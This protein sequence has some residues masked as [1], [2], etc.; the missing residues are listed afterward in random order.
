VALH[1]ALVEIFPMSFHRSILLI[2]I[3]ASEKP[4][5]IHRYPCSRTWESLSS[6]SACRP[7]RET[8]TALS[9]DEGSTGIFSKMKGRVD[10]DYQV[11]G[12]SIPTHHDGDLDD[13]WRVDRRH[14]VRLDQTFGHLKACWRDRYLWAAVELERF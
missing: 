3:G 8:L 12:L 6:A 9:L 2:R 13:S 10:A 4:V 11:I 1:G 5:A 14:R 7:D